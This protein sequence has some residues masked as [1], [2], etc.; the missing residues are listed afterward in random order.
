[1]VMAYLFDTFENVMWVE[2]A[3]TV[4]LTAADPH[5]VGMSV[6]FGCVLNILA[7]IWVLTP[8]MYAGMLNVLN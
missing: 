1:M 4:A 3:V 8:P 5:I 6:H 7:I 2:T